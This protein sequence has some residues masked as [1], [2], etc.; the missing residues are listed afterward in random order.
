M[1]RDQEVKALS[2]EYFDFF[3]ETYPEIATSIGVHTYDG[4]LSSYERS[5]VDSR[6]RR[7]REFKKRS[8][9]CLVQGGLSVSASI[10]ARL[11]ASNCEVQILDIEKLLKPWADPILYIDMG[12]YGLFLLATRDVLPLEKRAHYFASRLKEFARVLTEARV[13]LENPPAVFTSTALGML[14]GAGEFVDETVSYFASKVPRAKAELE[15]N[16]GV[17]MKAI[18]ES[19]EYIENELLP[20]SR[21]DF[22]IGR[23]VFDTKLRVEHML[24]T[25]TKAL[26]KMGRELLGETK[27]KIELLSGRLYPKENWKDVIE[28]IKENHPGRAELRKAYEEHMKKAKNFVLE[29]KLVPIP[30]G[31][32]LRVIDTPVFYRPILPYAAYLNPGPFD[33]KQEGLFF[34]TPVDTSAPEEIQ[35]DQLKG[36]SYAG[37]VLCALHEAYP[38]HHLQLIHSNRVQ[39]RLRHLCQS[40]VFAEGWALYCEQ[41]MKEQGFYTSG[42][43]ELFQLKDVLW[44]AA[45][46]VVDVGLHSGTMTFEEAIEFLVSEALIERANA[47][48]EVRRYTNTPSQPSSYAI[49]KELVLALREEEQRRLGP[50]FELRSFHER[51]LSSGTIPFRLVREEFEARE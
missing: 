25:D 13:N 6:L 24:D 44:R 22:A 38:G 11:I 49:G 29:K 28:R 33:E 20:R 46:V 31:E 23:E 21:G 4:K 7:L 34:V 47:V 50:A 30:P 15:A 19:E 37:M 48:A 26:E 27:T 18:K 10:D 51:L 12:L 43:I 39:S 40:T 8:E 42:D 32:E 9:E 5:S 36:H 3:V 17:C 35:N 16:A 1:A 14:K 2:D 45:R 41:L